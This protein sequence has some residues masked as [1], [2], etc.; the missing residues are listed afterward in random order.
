[1]VDIRVLVAF[2]LLQIMRFPFHEVSAAT[3]HASGFIH[4]KGRNCNR[5]I[6]LDRCCVAGKRYPQFRCSPLVSTKT[7]AILTFNRFEN[8]EDDTR[9][10][11]CDNRFHSDKELLVILSSGW[12]KHNGTSRCNKKIRVHANGRSV[13]AKV[14]DECDSTHGCDEEHGFEPP[15]RNNVLNASP[16]VWKALRLNESI[17]ESKVTWSD[18]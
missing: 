14:V 8:G 7:P 4:G 18:V 6:G 3:C 16:A 17:G 11:S 15:C 9:I 12:L 5:E 10:T 2:A 1:M 13:L